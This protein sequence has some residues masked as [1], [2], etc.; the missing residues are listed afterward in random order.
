MLQLV[1]VVL[2]PLEVFL[3]KLRAIKDFLSYTLKCG[4]QFIGVFIITF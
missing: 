3:C 4:K 2:T 1:C